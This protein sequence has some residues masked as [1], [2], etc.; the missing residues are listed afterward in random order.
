MYSFNEAEPHLLRYEAE[1][2]N[3]RYYTSSTS[4]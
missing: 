3:E 4:T 2:R 1:P